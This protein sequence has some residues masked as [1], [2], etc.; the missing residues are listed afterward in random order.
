MGVV[1][2][3]VASAAASNVHIAPRATQAPSSTAAAPKVTAIT[4]CHLHA[5]DLYC[6]AGETEYVVDIKVTATTDVPSQYTDCHA[7]GS[8]MF[9]VG[10]D[11]KDV[12]VQAEGAESEKITTMKQVKKT[13]TTAMEK[14]QPKQEL[15][16]TRLRKV[17]INTVTSTLV[18][19]I[20]Q[21][22]AVTV[23]QKLARQLVLRLL[24]VNLAKEITMLVSVSVSSS[25]FWPQVP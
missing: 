25:S 11:G 4:G 3:S 8:D 16:V 7:H 13:T 12:A 1:F 9:C 14:V 20:A 19:S 21:V 6:F 10:S 22:E 23:V 17:K 24:P 2:S 5:S 18:S 15:L